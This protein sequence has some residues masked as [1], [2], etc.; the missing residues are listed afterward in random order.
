MRCP[1]RTAIVAVMVAWALQ[2]HAMAQ[3]VKVPATP[4]ASSAPTV[5]NTEL[6]DELRKLKSEVAEARQ[7]K[8]QV[9]QLQNE[10]YNLRNSGISTGNRDFASVVGTEAPP[11]FARPRPAPAA[12]ATRGETMTTHT[13]DTGGCTTTYSPT[14]RR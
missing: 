2:I 11:S 4:A 9:I 10:V 3:E 12:P 13:L 8:D 14:F 7:L 1:G 6:L 5:T